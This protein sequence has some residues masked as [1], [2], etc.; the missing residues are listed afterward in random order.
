MTDSA[1]MADASRCKTPAAALVLSTRRTRSVHQ[2]LAGTVTYEK[3][4]NLTHAANVVTG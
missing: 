3:L 4:S 1:K 2:N